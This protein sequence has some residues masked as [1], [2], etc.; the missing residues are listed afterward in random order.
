MLMNAQPALIQ[1]QA[2]LQEFQ[3][4]AAERHAQLVKL[5]KN[6]LKS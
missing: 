3:R 5:L 1:K 6:H 4:I 2:A